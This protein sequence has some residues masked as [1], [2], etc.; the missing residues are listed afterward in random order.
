[1]SDRR[2]F[3]PPLWELTLSRL[4]E[5]WRDPSALFWTFGFPIVLA[6]ALG[7]AFRESPPPSSHVAVDSSADGSSEL[8]ALLDAEEDIDAVAMNE[9][10]ARRGL[11]TGKID[12]FVVPG[13]EVRYRHDPMR[14]EAKTA[15]LAVDAVIERA[16]GREDLVV[17][18]DEVGS[19]P[20]SRYIDF[21]V[22]GLIGLNIMGSAIWGIGFSVVDARKR[23]LLK[24]L[25]ATPM[26][27]A[28]FLLSFMLSRLL[29]LIA[30]VVALVG[31]G[32]LV[33]GVPVRGSLLALALVS[34]WGALALTGIAMLIA[35][36]PKSTEVASGFANLFMLPMWLLGGSFFSYE[37]F[38]EAALPF[39]RALP[40][41]ALND[42]L[43]K[44]MN[45]GLGLTDV[46]ME[47]AFLGAWGAISFAIA[48]RIFRWQ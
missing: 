5:F 1:M 24:R 17:S 38:P 10:D 4:R 43:R 7:I 3:L 31:F 45:E 48:L 20:G 29:F 21:L 13:S 9:T 30:E 35:A 8:V 23:R 14:V 22:P 19:E 18:R 2:E 37:R 34:M 33:F 16:R 12:L 15:R 27:R 26:S 25:A 11:A 6:I 39:I 42:G 28:H 36:R 47:L 44:I 46:M 40:L 41:T 32:W